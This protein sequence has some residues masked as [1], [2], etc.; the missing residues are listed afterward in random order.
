MTG[1]AERCPACGAGLAS[2]FA[3][4]SPAS[5]ERGPTPPLVTCS[6]CAARFLVLPSDDEDGRA[7]LVPAPARS[8]VDDP[9][10]RQLARSLRVLVHAAFALAG[11]VA[12]TLLTWFIPALRPAFAL[13]YALWQVLIAAAV[14]APLALLVAWLFVPGTERKVIRSGL[15]LLTGSL[16]LFFV[17]ALLLASFGLFGSGE[18]GP[19]PASSPSLLF[20][21]FFASAVG[22]GWLTA[23][24]A[25]QRPY[26]HALGVALTALVAIALLVLL[27]GSLR[28]LHVALAPA[29]VVPALLLGAWLRDRDALTPPTP[30]R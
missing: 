23:R 13:A 1:H 12:V 4:G 14:L 3:S 15:A 22:S 5:I 6:A 24:I 8:V 25:E 28:G 9:R 29:A 10:R 27:S 7:E 11:L 20:A 30:S 2:P 17:P 18:A 21:L 16:L 19:T 26:R